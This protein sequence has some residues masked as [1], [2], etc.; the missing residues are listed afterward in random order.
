MPYDSRYDR[1]DADS[2]SDSARRLARPPN[3]CRSSTTSCGS[4]PPPEWPPRSRGRHFRRRHL[5]TRPTS[6]WSGRG[7]RQAGTAAATSSPP[8]PRRCGEFSSKHARRKAARSTAAGVDASISTQPDPSRAAVRRSARPRRSPRPCWPTE[9]PR[10]AELV[11]LR[12][13]AGLSIEDAAAA[14][15]V[16]RATADR[17]WAYRP[18]LAVRKVYDGRLGRK[19]LIFSPSR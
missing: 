3:S 16:S 5:F 6:G 1:C 11:K 9:D 17:Y 10:Q 12:Y 4:S 19:E 7:R 13:F 14:L 18:G 15:D 2:G 8:P